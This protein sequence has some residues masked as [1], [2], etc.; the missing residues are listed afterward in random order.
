MGQQ[1]L[2]LILLVTVI[3]GIAIIMGL[4]LFKTERV[5]FEE[6]EYTQLMIEVAEQAQA[7]YR[8]PIAI[9]GGGGSFKNIS[10]NQIPCP[11]DFVEASNPSNCGSTDLTHNIQVDHPFPSFAFVRTYLRIGPEIYMAELAAYPEEI[12]WTKEWEKL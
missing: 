10:F 1:Q 9:G 11:L 6:A 4:R 3:V 8:K 5:A 7:W 12:R 2:L